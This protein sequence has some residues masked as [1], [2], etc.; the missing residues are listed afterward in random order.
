MRLARKLVIHMFF[1]MILLAGVVPVSAHSG[2]DSTHTIV[3]GP[4][5]WELSPAACKSINS[6]I[7]GSGQRHEETETKVNKD[8]SSRIVDEDVVSGTA[9]DARGATY[10]FL[11]TN[12]STRL[13]PTSGTPIS[14][15]MDDLFILKGD[16]SMANN[17]RV[18]FSWSWTYDPLTSSYWPPVDNFVQTSTLG[19]PFG[20]DPI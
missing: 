10:H 15:Q 13:V 19:D 11:Y 6:V 9:V 3:N 1:A 20:C 2:K 14:I 18:A 7:D 17:L 8:G 4:V 12:H 16:N 5:S